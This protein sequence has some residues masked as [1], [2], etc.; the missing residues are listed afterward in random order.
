ML[1]VKLS[2]GIEGLALGQSERG[3]MLTGV[4][5]RVDAEDCIVGAGR[6][7]VDWTMLDEDFDVEGAVDVEG[8]TVDMYYLKVYRKII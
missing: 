5:N 7:D 3:T 2:T 4:G 6:F 1:S 8:L